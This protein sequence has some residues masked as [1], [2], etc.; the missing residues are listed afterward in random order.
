MCQPKSPFH[1]KMASNNPGNNIDDFAVDIGDIGNDAL[2]DVT[3]IEQGP[4]NR[5][6]NHEHVSQILSGWTKKK[7]APNPNSNVRSGGEN[8]DGVL[9]AW[10]QE[11][12]SISDPQ[13]R[14]VPKSEPQS[15]TNWRKYLPRLKSGGSKGGHDEP[16]AEEV[17]D[18]E[19]KHRTFSGEQIKDLD[20]QVKEWKKLLKSISNDKTEKNVQRKV[21]E[22]LERQNETKLKYV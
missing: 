5:G 3:N 9:S 22:F 2:E 17:L 12:Q 18:D 11:G 8:G 7:R 19:E 13:R 4:Q 16:E 20:E 15:K 14:N 6:S 1:S 10:G 21:D